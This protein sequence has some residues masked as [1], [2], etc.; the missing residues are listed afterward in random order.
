MNTTQ[1]LGVDSAMAGSDDE[2]DKR[3]AALRERS[4]RRIAQDTDRQT[5]MLHRSEPR[6]SIQSPRISA[7]ACVY[8][9]VSDWRMAVTAPDPGEDPWSS[10]RSRPV[11]P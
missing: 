1:P 11:V 9:S 4:H 2:L 3:L 7:K 6:L 5:D 10:Q 8:L